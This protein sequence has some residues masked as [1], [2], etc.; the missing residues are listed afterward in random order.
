MGVCEGVCVDRREEGGGEKRIWRLPSCKMRVER[1][2]YTT[3]TEREREKREEQV[4]YPPERHRK[5]EEDFSSR[6]L[7]QD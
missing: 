1:E 4:P 7:D 2:Q 6:L 3:E 5:E